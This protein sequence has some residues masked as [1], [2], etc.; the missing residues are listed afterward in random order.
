MRDMIAFMLILIFA[1]FADGL[2]DKS[3]ALFLIAGALVLGT[4]GALVCVRPR[5]ARR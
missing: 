3:P 4:A 5:R 2:M 1:G